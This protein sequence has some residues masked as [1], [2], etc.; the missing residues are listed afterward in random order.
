MGLLTPGKETDIRAVRKAQKSME[1]A[2]RYILS[3]N[4]DAAISELTKARDALL[5]TT[6][7]PAQQAI[8]VETLVRLSKDY[9]DCGMSLDAANAADL[10]LRTSPN[11]LSALTAFSRALVKKGDVPQ[12]ISVLDRATAIPGTDKNIWLF[13]ADLYDQERRQDMVMFCL[14]KAIE[15]DPSDISILDRMVQRT[16]DKAPLLRKKADLLV[17]Q[18]KNEEALTAIDQAVTLMPR[19]VDLMLRKGEILTLLKRT[20]QAL[21]IYDDVLARD[22]SNALAHLYKA[23]GFKDKGDNAAALAQY[24]ESLRGDGQNKFTWNEVAALLFDL[25]RLQE[26]STAYDRA[27]GIDPE[28]IVAINGKLQVAKKN[29]ADEEIALYA[30]KLINRKVE[31]RSIFIER[32]DALFRLGKFDEASEA[33]NSALRHFQLDD[34]LLARRRKIMLQSGNMEEVIALAEAKLAKEK[35]DFQALMDLGSAYMKSTRFRDALKPLEKAAKVQ[36]SNEAPLI[37]IKESNKHIGKDKDVLDSCDRILRVNPVNEGALFDKAVALDRMNRK[38]DAVELYEQVMALD[39]DDKDNLKD[40]SLALFS[41]GRFEESLARSTLGTQMYPNQV[42][43][44]RVQGDSNF[45]LKHYADAV[46]SYTN[47][48]KLSP[49]EKRLIYSRGLALENA[50]RY[51]EAVAAY[52]E[53]L[54][55]DPK[56]KSVWLSKGV[57]LEWLQRYPQALDCYEES[58]RLDDNNKFVHVRTGQVLAKM[59]DHESAI[60]S[61]DKALE[62]AP[63]DVELLEMKK[64]ALKHTDRL[65]ELVKVCQKIIKLDGKNR[66][67]YVDLGVASH[68]LSRFDDAIEAFDV[69]L[70]I[71]SGNVAIL[72]YKKTSV[73]AKGVADEIISVCDSILKVS[74][75]DKPALMD[76][77]FA[78][79][80]LGR[81]AE[82]NDTYSMA[83][84]VDDRDKELHN[85]KGLVLIGLGRYADAVVEFDRSFALDSSDLMPLNNKGRA[86]LLMR[87]YNR[88]LQV[89][90]QCVTGQPSNPRFQSDRGRALASL[91]NLAEAVNAFDAALAAD[92]DDPQTWKYKGNVMFKLGQFQDC[93]I[94]LNRALELGAEEQGIYK[95]KGRALEELKHYNDALDAFLRAV[96]MDAS[97]A[98]AWER[99]AVIRLQLDDPA[100][101]YEAIKKA[102][103][104]DPK[105]RRMLMERGDICQRLQRPEEAIKSYDGAIVLDPS[106]PFAFYGRGVSYLKLRSYTEA[107][108]SLKKA[109][110][111]DPNF[112]QARESLK[113]ADQMLHEIEVVNQ[114]TSVLECEY[115][116]NRRMSKEEMFKECGI[117]YNS[118][119]EVSA[120]LDQRETINVELLNDADLDQYEEDSRFVLLAASR[121]PRVKESGLGLSD[122]M[123]ALPG[124]D[125]VRAKKV[126]SYVEKVNKMDL[127][128][129]IMDARTEKLLRTAMNLP[130]EKR[131]VMGIIETLGVGIYTARRLMSVIKT[132]RTNE[133][134]PSPVEAEDVPKLKHKPVNPKEWV[135]SE[136]PI[137]LPEQRPK[138]VRPESKQAP[139]VEYQ[140][141][142]GVPPM[143]KK[144]TRDPIMFGDEQKDLYQTFYNQEKRPAKVDASEVRGRVCLFHGEPAVTACVK[145]SSL[146]CEEC[147]RGGLCPRCHAPIEGVSKIKKAASKK[148]PREILEQSGSEEPQGAPESEDD[149]QSK[150]WS[151]L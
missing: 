102:L 46:T 106:D 111:L 80:R 86:Y 4:L 105:N 119:D 100:N 135:E 149:K 137:A 1:A 25:G 54:A 143:E 47:A 44:W 88:A 3:R 83:L 136:E 18:E 65:E 123:M 74:P 107:Q 38:D 30:G 103:A 141:E 16:E 144:T 75:S 58:Q 87:E 62:L 89:F 131:N 71:E 129:T 51:E 96:A 21:L 124:K 12:A 92:K 134:K 39:P 128:H 133:P 110:E 82:A 117:P 118:L 121:N 53:S 20:D 79:E 10:A 122:V 45:A 55:I 114:A 48:V 40:L 73:V 142:S 9:L 36:P 145:C 140:V 60:R 5:G 56:D 95:A 2:E 13:K 85:R 76:K 24:K 27:L 49:G 104:C 41:M 108:D 50:K 150:D 132:L 138:R 43:F 130:E 57:A 93:V 8:L 19:T 97:D 147:V 99:I 109:L 7:E 59:N 112:D 63:K 6:V 94:C 35:D 64:V 148:D 61:F 81:L 33:V 84:A 32:I 90:D 126:L 14:K 127:N 17:S 66:N 91:G 31:E 98:S 67:A 125:I 68:R 70:G 116:Q 72:N 42:A 77:A 34:E 115:R 52:D 151:R 28:L 78:L 101:A 146:L 37:C 26:S 69:A 11:D 113:A 139:A 22:S 15:L 29:G 120:F 23:R